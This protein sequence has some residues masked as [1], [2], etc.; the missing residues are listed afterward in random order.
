MPA[1]LINGQAIAETINQKTKRRVQKLKRLGVAPKLAV[2]LVGRDSA[3][4]TYVKKKGEVAARVGIDF[5][6]I[7]LPAQTSQAMLLAK[8]KS[9]QQDPALSGLIVQLP[10]P[11][12]LYTPEV[13]NAI[14]PEVDVDCLTDVNAGKL[15]MK[16]AELFPPT[17]AGI[18]T[19][20]DHLK[21]AIA[22]NNVVILGLGAL[23]GKPLAVMMINERASVTTINS[24]TRDVAAKCL[25]ADIIVS[26]VGKPNLVRGPMVKPGA[27]VIDAG[28]CFVGKKMCG[29]VNLPEVQARA[30]YVTPTPGGV[31][32][33]TVAMLLANTVTC[34]EQKYAS[35]QR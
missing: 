20:L 17:P 33:I 28:I 6:L 13:L 18:L 27:I 7:K 35:R 15:M 19:I 29:D 25:A 11:E 5:A 16:T 1:Q 14:A 3:S 8:L 2:I 12:P 22:E 31:G 9:L 34:A 23:V 24:R 30:A 21:V 10:L 4:E 26:A 32:P